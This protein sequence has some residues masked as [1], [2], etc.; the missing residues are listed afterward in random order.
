MSTK[1]TNVYVKN[2]AA[3]ETSFKEVD[4]V[5]VGGTKVF[6][7]AKGVAATTPEGVIPLRYSSS[8]TGP[9]GGYR[10]L[11]TSSEMRE[12]PYTSCFGVL[13]M[14]IQY[15]GHIYVPMIQPVISGNP[16]Y[17]LLRVGYS[18]G[19]GGIANAILKV[20]IYGSGA[21][22]SGWNITER[23]LINTGGSLYAPTLT[24]TLYKVYYDDFEADPDLGQYST[25]CN[26]QSPIALN[27]IYYE[28]E[29]ARLISSTPTEAPSTITVRSNSAATTSPAT[30]GYPLVY[31]KREGSGI[32]FSSTSNLYVN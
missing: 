25:L 30:E 31:S 21:S 17:Y 29:Y 26:S 5:Y 9:Y 19:S 6:E 20:K 18:K 2:R 7:K 15:M 8:G 10:S 1:I 14:P 22:T 12:L 16:A 27:V 28:M 32:K 11:Y 13:L 24:T 4:S 23:D 3:G